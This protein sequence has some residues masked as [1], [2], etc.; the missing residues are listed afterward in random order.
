[1]AALLIALLGAES[2]GKSVLAQDLTLRLTET[3]GLRC[4]MVTE[5]LRD[6]CAAKGRTPRADEQQ[7]IACAQ[8]AK[9]DAAAAD[10]DIVVCDTT[11]LMA[12]V[13]SQ[14]IFADH[15]L[16]AA[17]LA[18]HRRCALTL[19][20]ALDL[21][22]VADGLQRDGPHVRGPVDA[23]IRSALLSAGLG[24]SVVAGVGEARVE[25]A[26]NAV[27][28]L[29]KSKAM[30]GRGLFSRLSDRQDALPQWHWV[31]DNCD[32]PECEHSDMQAKT[33]LLAQGKT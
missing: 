22:W 17:G 12:A 11:A 2:T 29:L 15:G 16:I 1:M 13:Y 20:T 21:P 14:H 4:A 23:A 26:L 25:A 31:C 8:T 7:E 18:F 30:P 3:T 32:V 28:P 6:W 33:R 9:I 19:L 10:N 27:T 5:H 24:Y